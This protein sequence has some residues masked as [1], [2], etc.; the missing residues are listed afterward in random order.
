VI[1]ACWHPDPIRGE[2][3]LDGTMQIFSIRTGSGLIIFLG[4]QDQNAESI[5][6][7]EGYNIGQ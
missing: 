2:G 3:T 7:L 5:K 1:S 6:S 4:M